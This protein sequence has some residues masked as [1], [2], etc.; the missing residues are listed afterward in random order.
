VALLRPDFEPGMTLEIQD[1]PSGDVGS[2]W[3]VTHLVHEVAQRSFSRTVMQARE[4]AG[5]GSSLLGSLL[6]AAGGLL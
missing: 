3:V 6:S 1:I 2:N 5:A 4:A